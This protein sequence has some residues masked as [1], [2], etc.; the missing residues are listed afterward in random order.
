[1][2][3]STSSAALSPAVVTLADPPTR[4]ID[5]PAMDYFLIEVV[6]T[7]RASSAVAVAR[8]KK[9]EQEMIEAGLLQPTPIPPP[10]V[11]SKRDSTASSTSSKLDLK[12]SDEEEGVRVRL[13]AIGMH[14]GANVAER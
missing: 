5:G 9:V 2:N 10:P 3:A 14:V 8:T 4:L 6:N 12:V 11:P 13:E 7:L 1:M